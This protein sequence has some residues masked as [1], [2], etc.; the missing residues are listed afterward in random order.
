MLEAVFHGPRF[1]IILKRNP[2]FP[3]ISTR[4]AKTRARYFAP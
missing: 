1:T 2:C 3:G 4:A